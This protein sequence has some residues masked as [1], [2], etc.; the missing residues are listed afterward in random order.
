MSSW[1]VRYWEYGMKMKCLFGPQHKPSQGI[2]FLVLKTQS[3]VDKN[4]IMCFVYPLSIL[5]A[6][7]RHTHKH[8][9]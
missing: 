4:W 5:T 6:P 3:A 9:P 7:P 8:T 2:Q 1:N